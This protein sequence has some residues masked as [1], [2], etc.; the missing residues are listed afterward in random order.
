MAGE[1]LSFEKALGSPNLLSPPFLDQ[2]PGLE[3]H[4]K[5]IGTLVR[6]GTS[7]VGAHGPVSGGHGAHAGLGVHLPTVDVAMGLFE[8]ASTLAEVAAAAVA[9]SSREGAWVGRGS[10]ARRGLLIGGQHSGLDGERGGGGDQK[11]NADNGRAESDERHI[12]FE[13]FIS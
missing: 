8:V 12:L 4:N 11:N 9:A 6:I 7:S 5:V 3:S 13:S 2:A 10:D 1:R